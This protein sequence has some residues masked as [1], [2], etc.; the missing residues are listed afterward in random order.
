M[1]INELPAILASGS[2]R[3]SDML[4]AEGVRFAVL[5]PGCDEEIVTALSPEETVLA[6]AFR[7]NVAAAELLRELGERQAAG[8]EL[9]PDEAESLRIAGEDHLL[10]SG[11]TIVYK[12]GEIIGKPADERDAFR[13]LSALRG[14][15]NTVFS[16]A[17]VGLPGGRRLL[18]SARSDVYFGDYSDE[19]IWAY[20][21]TGEP[22]DKAG[23]YAIQ[24]AF[25]R[26][27]ERVDGPV[28]NVIGFP[29]E[30]VKAALAALPE[31]RRA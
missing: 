1:K 15:V 7:K 8:E 24:G 9:S 14:E 13:M 21:D 16:G 23:G 6:L 20:I 31:G 17:C 19:E 18:I 28:D 10:I 2:P 3:R 27:I 11:D 12:D 22:M 29:M 25:G 4:R 5:R 30:A 26:H